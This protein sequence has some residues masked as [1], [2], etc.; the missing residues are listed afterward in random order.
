MVDDDQQSKEVSTRAES[1]SDRVLQ[2]P[3]IAPVRHPN[4]CRTKTRAARRGRPTPALDSRL[5]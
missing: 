2:T 1:D 3:D 5:E 4:R